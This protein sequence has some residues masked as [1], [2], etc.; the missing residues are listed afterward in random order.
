MVGKTD[1]FSQII[2]SVVIKDKYCS[3]VGAEA[4]GKRKW[5]KASK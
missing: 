1:Q 2:S 4:A 5:E 3:I